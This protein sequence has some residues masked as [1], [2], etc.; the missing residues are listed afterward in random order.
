MGW[1]DEE[2]DRAIALAGS[3]AP[4]LMRA[5]K[6]TA[7]ADDSQYQ[8][9]VASYRS[10]KTLVYRQSSVNSEREFGALHSSIFNMPMFYRRIGL[11]PK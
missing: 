4:V 1:H 5:N 9:T 11:T 2:R 3:G 7:I 8:V 6:K 10:K